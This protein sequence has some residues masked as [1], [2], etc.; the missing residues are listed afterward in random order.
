MAKLAWRAT[1]FL[2]RAGFNL[3]RRGAASGIERVRS[4]ERAR[5]TTDVKNEMIEGEYQVIPPRATSDWRVWKQ[6]QNVPP[7]DKT[8]RLRWDSRKDSR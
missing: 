7:K 4:R 5:K 3:A 1:K 8:E 6:E 2:T